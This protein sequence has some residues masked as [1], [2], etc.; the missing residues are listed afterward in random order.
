MLFFSPGNI[1]PILK[2]TKI[3]A[4]WVATIGP[5][6]ELVYRG[7]NFK[8]RML[9]FINKFFMLLSMK[10][11]NMVIHESKYSLDLFIDKYK[12][13]KNHQ[14]LIE[15]GKSDFFSNDLNKDFVENESVANIRSVDLLCVSHF[16]P[17][18]NLEILISG[19]NAFMRE[20][21]DKTVK[22]VIC[23]LPVFEAYYRE[24]VLLAQR[25]R[26][27]NIIFAGGVSR[28]DLNTP[29]L[30]VIL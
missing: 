1:S 26:Y 15:C 24:I 8:D 7:I 17:Y 5:F 13:N 25:S 9:L 6:E 3:K 16:Y 10:S 2:T 28:V 11:S 21:A 27:K 12:L 18:K 14:Y 4:Q 20:N 29:T 23:G 22:L 19:F 30:G